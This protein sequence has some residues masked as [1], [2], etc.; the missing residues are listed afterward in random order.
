MTMGRGKKEE[1]LAH[2]PAYF[3]VFDEFYESLSVLIH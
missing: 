1:W 3:F 2:A